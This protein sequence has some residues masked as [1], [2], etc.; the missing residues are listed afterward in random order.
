MQLRDD[1]PNIVYPGH[2]GFFGGH[3][4]ADETPEIALE[5]ELFEEINYRIPQEQTQLF[6]RYGD[7]LNTNSTKNVCRHV[8]QVPLTVPMSKLQL[9]EGWDMALLTRQNAMDGGAYSENACQWR[10]M[11]EIHQR[12]LMDFFNQ[13]ED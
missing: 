13:Y 2:W 1:I 11:P 10:P 8:F 7:R 5:R 9:Q 6:G 12:I 4:E 3:L